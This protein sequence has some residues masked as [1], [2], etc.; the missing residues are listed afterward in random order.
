MPIHRLRFLALPCLLVVCSGASS[1]AAPLSFV[2]TAA[3]NPSL[4]SD[5][6]GSVSGT[7]VTVTL[8]AG[9]PLSALVP[10]IV[11]NGAKVEPP[12][13]SP[14]DFTKPVTYLVSASDGTT[15]T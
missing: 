1:S 6:R 9:T 8:P 11:C 15:R 3:E 12:S 10:T 5:V 13:G 4:A 7:Q 14:A 2:F